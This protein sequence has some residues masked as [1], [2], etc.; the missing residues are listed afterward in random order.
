VY[1]RAAAVCINRDK[2]PAV[3]AGARP[4]TLANQYGRRRR[5]RRPARLRNTVDAPTS[6]NTRRATCME[7]PGPGDVLGTWAH[8]RV[9]HGSILC[10]P[11]QPN[12]TH[13][14]WENLDPTRPNPIHLTNFT[15]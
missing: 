5:R 4:G 3:S 12:P 14:K 11:I 6:N 13:Y 7:P 10:D 2:R 8:P 1:R 9:V 15:A